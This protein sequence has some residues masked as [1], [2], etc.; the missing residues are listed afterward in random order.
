MKVYVQLADGTLRDDSGETPR[1]VPP[2][3]DNYDYRRIQDEVFV[4]DA[5]VEPEE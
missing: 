3:P 1:F 5:A 4:G 2:D